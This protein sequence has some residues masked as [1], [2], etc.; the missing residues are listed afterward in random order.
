MTL[1]LITPPPHQGPGLP[2]GEQVENARLALPGDL[3]QD[4]SQLLVALDVDG[5][6]LTAE[7][8]SPNVRRTVGSAIDAGMNLVIATGRGIPATRP[9]FEEL[10][11][12]E[13]YSVSSNGAQTIRWSRQHNGQLTYDKVGEVYFDPRAAVE[14]IL[15]V[16]PGT[17]LAMD[18]GNERMNVN[19]EFPPGELASIQDL[20]D[21][22]QLLVDPA[23]RMVIRA[24]WMSR[25]EFAEAIAAADLSEFECAIGWTAWADVTA[26]GTTKAQ[27]LKG[28]AELLGIHPRGTIAIGDGSNDIAMLNWAAHGVAMGGAAPEVVAAAKTTTGA[29][30]HD[31]AAAVLDALLERY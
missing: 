18:C 5:T 26:L 22:E 1:Q 11:L 8:A 7:G 4:P 10:E 23:V 6:L 15:A 29:V 14:A 17:H 12:N 24:P 13:G 28:L 27:S 25:E 31:G 21:L 20:R 19:L 3:P 2:Y 9:V 16:I 30:D